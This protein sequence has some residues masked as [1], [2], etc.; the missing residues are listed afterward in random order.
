[1]FTCSPRLDNLWLEAM[2]IHMHF[3]I[4]SV[5]IIWGLFHVGRYIAAVTIKKRQSPGG[6]SSRALNSTQGSTP[7]K[8]YIVVEILQACPRIFLLAFC[9]MLLLVIHTVLAITLIPRWDDFGAASEAWLNCK[10]LED[11]CSQIEGSVGLVAECE[12]HRNCG[13]LS[14]QSSIPPAALM[15][16][17]NFTRAGLVL[18]VGFTFVFTLKNVMYAA[19]RLQSC[20]C[21]GRNSTKSGKGY[22][23]NGDAI[24]MVY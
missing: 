17:Y 7:R 1:M 13:E 21:M 12:G 16:L 5:V 22:A 4:C 10:R 23:G 11:A 19:G 15:D 18:I 14:A 2:C 6:Q 20:K 8:T 24:E 3:L 9:M